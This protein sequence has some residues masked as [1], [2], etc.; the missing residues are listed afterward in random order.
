MGNHNYGDEDQN[1]LMNLIESHKEDDDI[2]LIVEK[3]PKSGKK[4][5]IQILLK[6]RTIIPSRADEEPPF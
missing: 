6:D 3:D 2:G 1:D 4:I 5:E